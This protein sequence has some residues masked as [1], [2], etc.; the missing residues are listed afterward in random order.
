MSHEN[1][2]MILSNENN[3]FPIQK[4][5]STHAIIINELSLIISSSLTNKS[6]KVIK[7]TKMTIIVITPI[8]QFV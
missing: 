2:F 5:L 6:Q 7:G 8:I 1:S 4:C 3:Y